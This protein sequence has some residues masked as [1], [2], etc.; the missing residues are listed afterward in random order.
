MARKLIL[1]AIILL[2][3]SVVWA[4]DSGKPYALICA[5]Y[6]NEVPEY[7]LVILTEAKGIYETALMSSMEMAMFT[8]QLMQDH[9]IVHAD[10]MFN[11]LKEV[12]FGSRY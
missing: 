11:V 6:R 8:I 2:A 3:V 4:Q 1:V 9:T 7:R 12:N 5:V 10:E